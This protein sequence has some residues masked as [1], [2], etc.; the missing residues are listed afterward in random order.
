MFTFS[1]FIIAF[2]F[3]LS[4]LTSLVYESLWIRTLSL[5]LGSTSTSMSLVLS[6]FFF[7]MSAGSYLSGSL[8]HKIKNPLK[9]YGIIEGFIGLYGLGLIYLLTHL[10]LRHTYTT[11]H[12]NTNMDTYDTSG[13]T[14]APNK[15]N[16]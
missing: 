15:N 4:G 13:E 7:G 9:T 5:S 3:I 14:M 1:R 6:I 16:S 2:L 12:N 10:S 11:T 8:I